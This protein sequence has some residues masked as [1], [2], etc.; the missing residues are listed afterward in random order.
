MY[1]SDRYD[2]AVQLIP[3]LEKYKKEEGVILAVPRGGV[4]IG[5]VLAKHLDF[6]LDLLMT[7][8]LSHPLSEEY[9][10]GAVGIEG[11]IIEDVENIPPQYIELGI[12]RI[13]Q[14]LHE[15]YKKFMGN[16]EPLEIESKT[17]IVVDDGI[18]TGRTILAAVKILKTKQPKKLVVAIP[19]AS[20]EAAERIGKEVDDFICLYLPPLFQGVGGYYSDFTQIT[21]DEVRGLLKQLTA[22]GHAA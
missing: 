14:Q 20:E 9:A 5:Y 13:R 8:K 10:I 19:V 22:R 18:A 4:P 21:D 2:A 3:Y 17:V 15:G 12:R 6:P 1:F 7:K 16:K 11:E